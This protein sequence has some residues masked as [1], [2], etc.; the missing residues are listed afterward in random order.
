[1]GIASLVLGII[2]IITAF[3]V[4]L[5]PLGVILAVVGLILGIVDTVKKGKTGQKK[6]ISIVGLIICSIIFVVLIVESLLV[7]GVGVLVYD[8]AKNGVYN[9]INNYYENNELDSEFNNSYTNS[10]ITDYN[11]PNNKV[12]GTYTRE[13]FSGNSF[14][15]KT[16]YDKATFKFNKDST[17][18]CSYEM[19]NTYKGTYEV[20]NGFNITAKASAIK[21]DS[22]IKNAEKLAEDIKDVSEK[23]MNDD[24]SSLLNTYLLY[25]KV[26][27]VVENG[28]TNNTEVLQPF[29]IKYNTDTNTGTA[30]NI[31]GQM[32]GTFNLK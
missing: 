26:T 8:S 7:L 19:G 9:E 23:M 17:F 31:Y 28:V 27:Q 18:E 2:G 4:I 10:I 30:V 22:S 25:L 20:Y 6:G 13:V 5:S 16:Y 12:L 1:M 29:I 32:S 15:Y 21:Q 3:T 11:N 24:M 14:E